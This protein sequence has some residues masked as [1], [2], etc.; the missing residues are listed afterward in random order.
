MR[1]DL[2]KHGSKFRQ[3]DSPEIH[4]QAKGNGSCPE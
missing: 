2:V 1:P 3:K 4:L